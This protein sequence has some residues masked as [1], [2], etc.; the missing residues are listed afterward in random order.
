MKKN[1]PIALSFV[2]FGLATLFYFFDYFLQ[3]VPGVFSSV[4]TTAFSLDARALGRLSASFFL[5]YTLMQL[6]AG[7]LYDKF[8]GRIV[9]F[10]AA[11]IAS[12]GAYLF[13]IADTIFMANLSRM[14]MGGG[15]AFAFLGALYFAS[16]WFPSKYFATLAGV[17]ALVG[18]IGAIFGEGL[19]A[20]MLSNFGW[21]DTMFYVALFGGILAISIG[22]L[23]KNYPFNEQTQIKKERPNSPRQ[24]FGYLLS[25]SQVWGLGVYCFLNWSIVSVFAVLWGIP[26][27]KLVYNMRLSEASMSILFLW[28]GVGIGSPLMGW[29]SDVIK[30]RKLPLILC[31]LLAT[32]S[33][34]LL[35][36]LPAISHHMVD[37]LLFSLGFAAAGPTIV[38][39]AVKDNVPIQSHNLCN[40]LINMLAVVSGL[41][42]Q[43][44]VGFIMNIFWQNNITAGIKV[45]SAHTYTYALS[46]LP[47][48]AFLSIL[49]SLF[50][51]KE[52]Y[53]Q[54]YSKI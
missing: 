16:R 45:Y 14:L 35:L 23:A 39:A 24:D 41:F 30:R 8:G 36:Y 47:F 52:T 17:V 15:A 13:S 18:S 32:I 46:L 10:C 29:F 51:I 28:I 53:C 26:Y 54:E 40:G 49:V 5:T 19:L 21:R 37:V 12:L 33:F 3:V 22:M 44:T 11:L 42:L 2:V 38:F 50:W 25:H 9:I 48:V 31:S 34:L 1:L 6:P 27:L 4:L 20:R 43:P 7:F